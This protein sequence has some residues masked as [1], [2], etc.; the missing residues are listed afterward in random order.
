MVSSGHNTSP[1]TV[2]GLLDYVVLFERTFLWPRSDTPAG[3]AAEQQQH[4]MFP[5]PSLAQRTPAHRRAS[6]LVVT[7]ALVVEP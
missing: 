6:A 3:R 7:V 4:Y 1:R 5:L 2:A